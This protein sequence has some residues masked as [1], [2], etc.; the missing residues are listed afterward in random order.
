MKFN[1]EI[2]CSPEEVRRL[3]GLPDLTALHATYLSKVEETVKKG[4]SPEMVEQMV[5]SWVPMGGAGMDMIGQLIGG[6]AG[7]AK[8]KKN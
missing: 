5:R 8:G 1:I 2:D 4:V 7:A 6:L 3:V